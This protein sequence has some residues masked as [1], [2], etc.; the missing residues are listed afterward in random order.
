M[1]ECIET[2]WWLHGD[3]LQDPKKHDFDNR[4]ASLSNRIIFLKNSVKKSHSRK[5]F[6]LS[7]FN[8]IRTKRKTQFKHVNN[9]IS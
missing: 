4:N 5:L 7:S 2:I 3:S 1:H 6:L 8:Y 9:S